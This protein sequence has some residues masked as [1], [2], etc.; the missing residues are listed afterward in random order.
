MRPII[1]YMN[2]FETFFRDEPIEVRELTLP[3]RV[4]NLAHVALQRSG[5]ECVFVPIR[6]MQFMGVIDAEEIIFVDIQAKH[7]VEVAWTH[8]R[9]QVRQ[10]LDEP[11]PYRVEVYLEKGRE[12]VK[13][14]QGEFAKALEEM[15][16]RHLDRQ[17]AE[18]AGE[19]LPLSGKS[20][21][22]T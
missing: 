9:P 16:K 7:L 19:V 4:Y 17:Q 1:R 13:R 11:V 22:R 20:P 5:R 6:S 21:R 14:L 3:A 15:E 10:S 8:F 18:H 2:G 12:S